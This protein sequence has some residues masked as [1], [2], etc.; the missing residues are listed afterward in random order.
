MVRI[1]ESTRIFQRVFCSTFR[2]FFQ[3]RFLVGGTHSPFRS[4][5]GSRSPH[6]AG[7][8]CINALISWFPIR[9][10][11]LDD[12]RLEQSDE[13]FGQCVVAAVPDASDGH[14]DSGFGEPLG[15]SNGHILHAAARVVG[16]SARHRTSLAD[17]LVQGVEDKGGVGRSH[18]DVHID[19]VGD[20]ELI[21]GVGVVLGTGPCRIGDRG[22]LASARDPLQALL[23]HEP[24]H[25]A[26][27]GQAPPRQNRP[28]P[29]PR[30]RW[31]C[32]APCSLAPAP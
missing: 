1:L 26:T 29:S 13:G 8:C 10:E 4:G 19:E 32:A 12:F 6:T 24:L 17:G 30:S 15:V 7:P 20:P 25:G 28:T 11:M 2:L 27:G 5:F 18:H 3:V 14:V 21:G 16:Q 23:P 22:F 9:A 31:R